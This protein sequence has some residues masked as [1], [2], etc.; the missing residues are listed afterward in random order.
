M[1]QTPEQWASTPADP[2]NPIEDVG[3]GVG[4][5]SP[6]APLVG[7]VQQKDQRILAVV[8][9]ACATCGEK[10]TLQ[11]SGQALCPNGHDTGDVI[12]LGIIN[13]RF[14]NPVQQ[15]WWKHFGKR[16]SKRRTLKANSR[17]P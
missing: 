17:L 9:R 4:M 3:D 15:F 13:A 7:D 2:E 5:V 11:D 6:A 8:V 1:T 12:D 10:R 14:E 16:L